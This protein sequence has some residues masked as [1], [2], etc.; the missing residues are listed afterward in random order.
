[1]SATNGGDISFAWRTCQGKPTT[2]GGYSRFDAIRE[3]RTLCGHWHQR[4]AQA[5]EDCTDNVINDQRA[6]LVIA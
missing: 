3:S 1:L 6:P 2:Q 4:W 5:E